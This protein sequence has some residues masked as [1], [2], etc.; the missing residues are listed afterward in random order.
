[1]NNPK[2]IDIGKRLTILTFS[3]GLLYFY[4]GLLK[5]S[6]SLSPAEEIGFNT[7][8]KLTFGLFPKDFCLY[9]LALLEVSIGICLMTRIFLKI[10]VIVAILH[11]LMTF[12]P[13]I[14]F[15][16][17]IFQDS[18]VSPSLLGQYIYKNIIIICALLL[19]YPFQK[20]VTAKA[21]VDKKNIT[22]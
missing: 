15:P 16:D 12:T 2:N 13:I 11:L 4:F 10:T 6:P 9:L 3:I 17:L 18:F 8:C 21:V 1:M 22:A 20:K 14:F 19:I 7:V 5:C